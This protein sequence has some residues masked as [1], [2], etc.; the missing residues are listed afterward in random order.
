MKDSPGPAR[1]GA[2]PLNGGDGRI[3]WNLDNLFVGNASDLLRQE[4]GLAD[5]VD[6]HAPFVV[7]LEDAPV[8][9]VSVHA[10]V[11]HVV[12]T[13]LI[14]AEPVPLVPFLDGL[15]AEGAG[16]ETGRL[17]RPLGGLVH[18]RR[19]E[20]EDFVAGSGKGSSGV[21]LFVVARRRDAKVSCQV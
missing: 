21:R 12:M 19:D 17:R 15:A 10:V 16:P 18:E 13:V 3:S 6:A 20:A 2:A 8:L 7:N 1:E 4:L 14:G 5:A 9:K 11:H